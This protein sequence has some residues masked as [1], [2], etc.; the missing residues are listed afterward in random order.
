MNGG[1]GL[2]VS[3]FEFES[4]VSEMGRV[5][6]ALQPADTAARMRD[7]IPEA[8]AQGRDLRDGLLD[9]EREDTAKSRIDTILGNEQLVA[10]L[11]AAAAEAKVRRNGSD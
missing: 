4:T 7:E 2:T 1:L 8:A 6:K 5:M 9:T 3:D 11:L 10:G